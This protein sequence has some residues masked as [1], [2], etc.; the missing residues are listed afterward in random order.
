MQHQPTRVQISFGAHQWNQRLNSRLVG[1][2][3]FLQWFGGLLVSVEF[4]P[5]SDDKP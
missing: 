5:S 3:A 1:Y 2:Y 4:I